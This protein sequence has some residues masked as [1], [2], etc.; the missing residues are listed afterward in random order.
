MNPR[1]THFDDPPFGFEPEEDPFLSAPLLDEEL[2]DGLS[3]FPGLRLLAGV[4]GVMVV[5]GIGFVLWR[6]LRPALLPQPSSF[7][8]I[9]PP[10]TSVHLSWPAIVATVEPTVVQ[11][12][13]YVTLPGLNTTA[14]QE[15]GSG[16][17]YTHTG[18]VVTN[19]H[20]VLYGKA[21]H[22]EVLTRDDTGTLQS[23]AV[24]VVGIDACAD[25]AV[26][27]LP[28]GNY[29]TPPKAPDVPILKGEEVAALGYVLQ[30]D[31]PSFTQGTV[32]R[33][34]VT[35]FSYTDL[36]QHT[37]P[38]NPGN[39]GGPLFD[40]TGRLIGVNTLRVVEDGE[41]GLFFAVSATQVEATWQ[42]LHEQRPLENVPVLQMGDTVTGEI[43][44]AEDRQC[45]PL[46]LEAG[47]P[48]AIEVLGDDPVSPLDAE[49]W[50]Y[51]PTNLFLD[52][53]DD[54]VEDVRKARLVITP[55]VSG[56]YTV[57]VM[58]HHRTVMADHGPYTLTVRAP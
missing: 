2:D 50:L 38:I 43:R 16:V 28:E 23:L 9:P 58:S 21:S 5:F 20:V 12:R 46:A 25:L 27:Q 6:S 18:E 22:I 41:Q 17:I 45:W 51:S 55:E 30:A 10:S 31:E 53:N 33:T 29:P 37:A 48:V 15:I 57:V 7:S 35:L 14:P 49:I 54:S 52:Y 8:T 32:S 4:I 36:I 13:S 44:G 34:G 26:L 3:P 39:S 11:V 24:S 1:R 42:R 40:R 19:A 56:I 47:K